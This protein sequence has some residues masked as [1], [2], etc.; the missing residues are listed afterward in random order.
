MQTAT[1]KNAMADF[2][3]TQC[4]YAD[5]YSTAAGATAGTAITGGTP[6]Y[7]SKALA[8]NASSNGVKATNGVPFD[9]PSGATVAGFGLKT[10][11]AGAYLDGGSLPSQAF[12]SQGTYTLTVTFTQT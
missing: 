7:A 6:A 9:I 8:W 5:L 3:A 4:T 1:I 11:A 10:G 2:Y 12:S